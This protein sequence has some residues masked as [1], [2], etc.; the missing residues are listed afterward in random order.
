MTRKENIYNL[1]L[2][3]NGAPTPFVIKTM[4]GIDSLMGELQTIPTDTII[5]R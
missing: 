1:D 2:L 4:E 3:Q 5:T